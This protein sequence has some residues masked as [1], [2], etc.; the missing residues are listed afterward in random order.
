MAHLGLFDSNKAKTKAAQFTYCK[1]QKPNNILLLWSIAERLSNINCPSTTRYCFLHYDALGTSCADTADKLI[2]FFCMI[3]WNFISWFLVVDQIMKVFINVSMDI[4]K[5]ETLYK[6]KQPL[7]VFLY[8]NFPTI[9]DAFSVGYHFHVYINICS[10]DIDYVYN[11]QIPVQASI[12]LSF[13]RKHHFA[14]IKKPLFCLF[15]GSL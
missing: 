14:V 8:C 1:R 15:K 10:T 6:W 7:P 13:L 11:Q 5:Y 4:C 3:F 2:V 9:L 12:C